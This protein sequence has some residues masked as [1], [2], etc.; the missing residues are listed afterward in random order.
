[1]TVRLWLVRHG[2]TEW[3]ADGRLNGWQDVPLNG[4]GRAQAR[5]VAARLR[6]Q[7]FTA[8]WSSDLQRAIETARMAWSEPRIDRRLRELD[9]GELEGRRWDE[10]DADT[11]RGLT[12]FDQF[13]APG[14]ESTASLRSRVMGF[15]GGLDAG[16]HL[17]FTHGGVMRLLLRESG[18]DARV[19]PGKLVVVTSDP[20]RGLTLDHGAES[21]PQPASHAR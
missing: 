15:I 3:S 10:L 9:F 11:Q 17:V 20:I 18:M 21:L 16:D 12:G 1:M 4:R 5:A 6:G 8:T 2:E 19:E 14:G 13:A 7:R